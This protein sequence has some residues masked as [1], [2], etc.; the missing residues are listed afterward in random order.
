MARAGGGGSSGGR[1]GG[2]HSTSRSSG[3]HRVGSSGSSRAG[4]GFGSSRPGGGFNGGPGVPGGP[5]YRPPMYGAPRGPVWHGGGFFPV[6]APRRRPARMGCGCGASVVA[7][8]LIIL[9]FAVLFSP[10]GGGDSGIPAS[11]A[12]REKVS[13]GVAYHNDCIIDELGWFDNISRTEKELQ[14]FYN[15]TGIQP[16]IYL[17][18]YDASLTTDAEKLA[19][20]EDWYEQNIDN[21]GTFLYIYFAEADQDYDV[22]YM[23]YVNGKQITSVMD[24]EAVDIFWAYLDNAWY[25]NM[26]TDDLFV[27]VFNNTAERIMDKTTTGADIVKWIVIIVGAVILICLVIKLMKVKRQN[28][29]EANEETERILKTPLNTSDPDD[30]LADK[31]TNKPE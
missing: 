29:K 2:G 3:G 25:S 19:F 10:A 5:G 27:T 24:A 30:D 7:V 14:S 20:A 28:E 31:Y 9:I 23:C 16:Y 18:A 13:T 6:G 12:N 15:K 21:E 22:G 26:S 11:T 17:R 8:L 4:A 1:S